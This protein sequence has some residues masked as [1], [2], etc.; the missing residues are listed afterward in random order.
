MP[1][2]IRQRRILTMSA[3]PDILAI[4][5]IRTIWTKVSRGA[6]GA[7]E[8]NAV[9]KALPLPPVQPGE[10]L[11]LIEHDVT[12]R[13]SDYFSNPVQTII[14]F[15]SGDSLT[16][17]C[18]RTKRS[19][20]SVQLTWEYRPDDAGAPLRHPEPKDLFALQAGQWARIEY[21]GRF[22]HD[23]G[24]LY[25][26]TVLNIGLMPFLSVNLFI[27]NPPQYAWKSMM[28]LR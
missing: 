1:A 3:Q 2:R 16:Y 8:R 5:R 22:G 26:K 9:P 18:L 15:D 20:H 23:D 11:P 21:N 14:S 17:G 12:F 4:Q 27:E 19:I 24:W 28:K 6:A 25:E 10:A 13:E 7:R